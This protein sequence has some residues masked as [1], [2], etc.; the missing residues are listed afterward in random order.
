MAPGVEESFSRQ[1]FGCFFKG[2][3]V[4][5]LSDIERCVVVEGPSSAELGLTLPRLMEQ[6]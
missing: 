6:N 5:T 2:F 1:I 4:H 3:C